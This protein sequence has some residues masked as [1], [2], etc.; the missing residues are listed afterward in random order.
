MVAGASAQVENGGFEVWSDLNLF[1]QPEMG[2]DVVTSNYETFF[3]TGQ[4]NVNPIPNGDG[5]ALHMENIGQGDNVMPAYFLTGMT[6]DSEG[7]LLVFG[8]GIPATDPNV[9]GVSVDLRYDIPAESPG[10]L[11]VQFKLQGEPVG[12]GNMGTGTFYFPI[13]GEKAEWG[14]EVFDFEAPFNTSYDQ[15]VIG[16]ACSDLINE[17]APFPADAWLEADNLAFINSSDEVPNGDFD[18]WAMVPPISLPMGVEVD[19][20]PFEV[21]FFKSEDAFSGN[22]ALGLESAD[23]DGYIEAGSA[24]MGSRV[25]DEI[26]PT[27][28][29]NDEH[30]MISFQYKYEAV[31][32]M[33]EAIVIFYEDIDG[34]FIPSFFKSIELEPTDEYTAVEYPFVQDLEENFVE[35]AKV[36]IEFKSS[37]DD[38][39]A[40]AGSLLLVDD[41]EI[42]GTLSSFG[43]ARI[44]GSPQ[45][46]AFP[47]PT[48]A[49]V[50]FN[51]GTPRTGF[52]RVYNGQG[53][54]VDIVEFQSAEELIHNL[55]GMPSGKY[56]FRFYHNGGI[57][58]AR[59]MKL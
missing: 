35:A 37:K 30:T 52:Y 26:V 32:D 21:Q 39:N 54:Q 57:E 6:P 43:V 53:F 25:N 59:V 40:E 49:R 28:D 31:S 58:T 16:I 42:S 29:V 9:T 15:V 34:E 19:L 56:V 24:I 55:Y 18:T 2:I 22:Y 38:M 44:A 23:R 36:A 10:F 14:E 4:L 12:T 8:G 45:V 1:Q 13:S 11:I 50:I 3:E 20:N 47:N 27:I 33:A 17:D 51:F 5:F 46:S 41:V 7:E 48:L